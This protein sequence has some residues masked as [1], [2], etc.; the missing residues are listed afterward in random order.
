MFAAL[1]LCGL[2]VLLAGE[3]SGLEIANVSHA[4]DRI[5]PE[6]G[7]A[8]RVRFHLTA[9]S[10]VTLRIYDAR[11]RLVREITT[12]E[13]LPEGDQ[14]LEWDGRDGE[15]RVVP[16]EAYSYTLEAVGEG[17]EIARWDVTDFA[18]EAVDVAAVTWNPEDGLVS[19]RLP[20]PARVRLRIGLANDG[21]LLRT[22]LNWVPR[23]AGV[24]REPWDGKGET[25]AIDLA[26][27]P[28]LRLDATAFALPQNA[29]LVGP[30]GSETSL[31]PLPEDTPRRAKRKRPRQH[32]MFDYGR[33][34][35]GERGDFSAM[36]SLPDDLER[37]PDGVP[38]V[39]GP[40]P[41]EIDVPEEGFARLVNQRSEAVFYVDGGFAFERETGFLPMTWTW[42]PAGHARGL[43]YLSVNLRGYEGHFGIATIPVWVEPGRSASTP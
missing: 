13:S 34:D 24:H 12:P 25:G 5:E 10:R 1:L 36:I 14:T 38:I 26:E 27:H 37:T 6:A 7:E 22:L 39:R 17:G 20:D 32:R 23:T 40:V 29:I 2:F 35:P 19:Y 31:L 16:P 28:A 15:G 9:P 11:D 33:Q 8:A 43:H 42:D 30:P 4:P 41:V 3:G 18:G 21:P